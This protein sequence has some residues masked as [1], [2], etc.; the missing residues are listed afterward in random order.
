MDFNTSTR[1]YRKEHRAPC[2]PLLLGSHFF[3]FVS[4]VLDCKKSTRIH[5]QEL[6]G[7]AS[8]LASCEAHA[9]QSKQD[10]KTE[11]DRLAGTITTVA[12]A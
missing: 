4:Q 6:Q 3:L 7:T 11:E 5:R 2:H 9:Q 8:E 1:I 10:L 12:Q